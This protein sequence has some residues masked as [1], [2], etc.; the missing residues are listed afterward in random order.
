MDHATRTLVFHEDS[1]RE[2]E[3]LLERARSVKTCLLNANDEELGVLFEEWDSI[4]QEVTRM[5]LR[6]FL[7]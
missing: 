4:S 6:K 5:A 2:F 3:R 1:F 7:P